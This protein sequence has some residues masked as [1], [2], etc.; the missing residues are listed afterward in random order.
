MSAPRAKLAALA[1]I[2]T[3]AAAAFCQRPSEVI[4]V[5]GPRPVDA[6]IRELQRRYGW[7]VTY[8]EYPLQFSGDVED[9]TAKV[10][11]D[12]KPGEVPEPSKR[13]LI[14]R[15]RAFTFAYDPPEDLSSVPAQKGLLQRLLQENAKAG[16][17]PT[18]E[19][20]EDKGR[21]HVVPAHMRDASGAVGSINPILDAKVTIPAAERSGG[22]F[23]DALLESVSSGSG[24]HVNFGMMPINILS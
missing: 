24:Q 21:L 10:R 12:L 16:V 3:A 15:D 13:V 14:S 23:L 6:A 20:R 9:V 18:F 4:S 5:S 17:S 1:F 2:I 11:K 22:Q 19:L 8:E 7:V